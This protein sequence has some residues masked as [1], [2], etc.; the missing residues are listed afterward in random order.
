MKGTGFLSVSGYQI[1]ERNYRNFFFL[2]CQSPH[3]S[4]ILSEIVCQE[5]SNVGVA[6]FAA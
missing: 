4:K 2:A 5:Y 6:V 1:I 3:T